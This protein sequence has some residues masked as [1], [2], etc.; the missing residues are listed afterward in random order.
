MPSGRWCKCGHHQEDHNQEHGNCKHRDHY[1]R[2][3]CT[4]FNPLKPYPLE[5][6][7]RENKHTLDSIF[8]HITTKIVITMDCGHKMTYSGE[9]F[10]STNLWIGQPLTCETCNKVTFIKGLVKLTQYK[11]DDPVD[12][13][14]FNYKF[15]QD[16]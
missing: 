12:L 14:R 3:V 5:E 6:L 13:D 8:E 15:P 10:D 11:S 7:D 9:G 2:R 1:D 4:K 16:R